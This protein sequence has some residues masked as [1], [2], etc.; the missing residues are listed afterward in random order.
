MSAPA[1]ARGVVELAHVSK[2]FGGTRA[3]DGVSL[4]LDSGEVH[5]LVG[6]NGAGKST[7]IRIL[8]GAIQ[9]F[10]GELCV[11]GRPARFSGPLAATRA[12]IA[13]IHQELSLVG[14]LSVTDNIL[15]G[16]P[17]SALGWFHTAE[18][19]EQ[20]RRHLSAA[21]IDADP[22]ALVESLPLATRQ[23]VEVAR[24]LA[25]GADAL[26]MDEPT[27]ALDERDAKKLLARIVDIRGAGKG[28]LFVSHRLEEVLAIADRVT[29]LR[30]GKLVWTRPAG[31]VTHGVLV[32]AIAGRDVNVDPKPGYA[33]ATVK[34]SGAVPRLSVQNL[35]TA[36]LR[37]GGAAAL[38]GVSFEL[39]KGEILGVAGLE[40]SG[41]RELPYA[42]FG[43]RAAKGEVSADGALIDPR[44]VR[45]CVERGIVLVSGDRARSAL[46]PLS[47]IDNAALSSL[48]RFSRAGVVQG[49]ALEQEVARGAGELQV[50]APSLRAPIE[51]LSG[52]NQQKVALLRAL[53]A[54]PRVVLLDDPTRGIDIGAREEI[55]RILRARAREGMSFLLVS[56]DLDELASLT[57]RV[58]VLARGRIAEEL[59]PPRVSRKNILRAAMTGYADAS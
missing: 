7:L 13:T 2:S 41:A 30:D 45:R 14:A 47:V 12:G 23:L 42:I 33:A 51:Q 18:R 3:L 43:A 36:P 28:V 39:A 53:M 10:E 5:A 56:S 1:P 16:E 11:R 26:V 58:L 57:D 35:T 20:A 9:D 24:A 44:T 52:G 48:P 46:R 32:A 55:G 19:R 15:L 59:T 17:G 40:G 54:D 8:S 25:R 31:E 4:S 22:D 6:E 50:S 34:S 29:V 37:A 49:H 27:S 38:V 21:G